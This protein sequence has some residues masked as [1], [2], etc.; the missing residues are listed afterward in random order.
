VALA[1]GEA[2]TL[3]AGAEFSAP[4]LDALGKHD[5]AEMLRWRQTPAEIV[6][7]ED[8]SEQLTDVEDKLSEL[9][10]LLCKACARKWDK[11]NGVAAS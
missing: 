7:A 6:Q 2:V 11:A 9:E 5:A 8:L 3:S 4:I 1:G 10:S